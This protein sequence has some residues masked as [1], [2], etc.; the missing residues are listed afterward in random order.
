MHKK[1]GKTL[2]QTQKA[3]SSIHQINTPKLPQTK[4]HLA[5][6]GLHHLKHMS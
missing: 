6:K 4:A 3:L 5:K 1:K 2:S